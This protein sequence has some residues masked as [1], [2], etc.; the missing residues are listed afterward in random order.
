MFFQ[1]WTRAIHY[2]VSWLNTWNSIA[3][4]ANL[5]QIYKGR[6]K[7]LKKKSI[8]VGIVKVLFEDCKSK[9]TCAQTEVLGSWLQV[10]GD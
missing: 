2:P 4:I 9:P 10:L 1:M 6:R 7:T 5:A 8:Q 3:F